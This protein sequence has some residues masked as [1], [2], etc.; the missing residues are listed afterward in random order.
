MYSHS[1]NF[2][3]PAYWFGE[4][5]ARPA[6]LFRI[7][8]ALILLKDAVYHLFISRTFY[9]DSGIVPLHVVETVSRKTRFSLLDAAHEHWMAQLF[10]VLWIVVVMGLLLGY[11][12]RTMAVLNF[13]MIVSI[14]ERNTFVL[15][16]ADTVLRVMSFWAIFL[17]LGAHY[18]IEAVQRRW[19]RF[20]WTNQTADLRVEAEPRMAFAL[21]L[22]LA[23]I[24]IVVVYTFTFILKLPGDIWT[25]GD[26]LHFALQIRS[27]TLPTGDFFLA[28]SPA[29]I[30]E[31]LTYGTLVMEGAF[32]FLVFLPFF[33]P[34][35]RGLGLLSGFALHA[36]IA[37]LMSVPNFSMT[38]ISTY[39][40][41]FP[42]AWVLA[43]EH[44]AMRP[45]RARQ[46]MLTFNPLDRPLGLLLAVT[47][48]ETVQVRPSE[49]ESLAGYDSWTVEDETGTVYAGSGAWRMV[50]A[51][52][53]LSRFFDL[54]LC[55]RPVRWVIWSAAILC[56]GVGPLPLKLDEPQDEDARPRRIWRWTSRAAV[57]A[58][59]LPIMVLVLWWN[60]YTIKVDDGRLVDLPPDPAKSLMQYSSM[61]QSWGM[62]A[63]FPT[64]VDGWVVVAG[65]F[66]DG[67]EM[68]LMTEQPVMHGWTR[69]LWGP[70]SR[71]KKFI[72]NMRRDRPTDILEA[73]G[74]HYCREYNVKGRLPEGQRLAT[75]EIIFYSR[76][77]HAPGETENEL[78]AR[79]LWRHWCFEEYQY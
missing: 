26:A 79:Q 8:L 10:I 9:S 12:T 47:H 22:R 64:N 59:L 69:W 76:R 20:A 3:R 51:Y 61:W 39:T 40:L 44:W 68:D 72:S 13:I 67:T 54:L 55:L 1:Y 66:E 75:L 73:W 71:W 17:P 62:F 7:L 4:V 35:L 58:V 11:R 34:V 50:A 49:D 38:M 30:L 15:N 42:P 16:G 24:Q 43:L 5:D 33:Q 63:P 41:F 37:L 46:L 2:L 14:H 70:H 23:Q 18:S 60:L 28:N 56:V 27:L 31:Y 36:G 19:R 32:V 65:H 6:G 53:P 45:N 48:P 21:P 25:G 78:Q 29:W 52:L 74:G 77:S 57:S